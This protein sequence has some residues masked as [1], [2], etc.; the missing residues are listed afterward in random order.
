ML[1]RFLGTI[2]SSAGDR[3]TDTNEIGKWSG[4]AAQTASDPHF[5]PSP[6]GARAAEA[7]ESRR[8]QILD[9][10]TH[11]ALGDGGRVCLI[12]EKQ[13]ARAR[14]RLLFTHEEDLPPRGGFGYYDD[15][16]E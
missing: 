6:A 5:G 7:G 8:F 3:P 10:Y 2:S 12:M 15:V 13:I 1:K 4:S 11:E 16:T 14:A 9:V